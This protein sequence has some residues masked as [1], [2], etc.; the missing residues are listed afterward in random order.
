MLAHVSDRRGA[1]WPR[2]ARACAG[3]GGFA[4]V[5]ACLKDMFGT[6]YVGA[7]HGMLI[8]ACSAAGC[9]AGRL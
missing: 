2:P 1:R 5:P 4:T 6:R 9:S 7:I 8:T 3:G